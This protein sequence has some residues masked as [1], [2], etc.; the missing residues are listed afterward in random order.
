MTTGAAEAEVRC[1]AVCA[2]EPDRGPGPGVCVCVC[3]L[4]AVT[5]SALCG[6]RLRATASRRATTGLSR[7]GAA[8]QAAVRGFNVM[9]LPPNKVLP[10]CCTQHGPLPADRVIL[11]LPSLCD[12][13]SS[14][15][16]LPSLPARRSLYAPGHFLSGLDS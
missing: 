5:L 6:R 16:P 1:A 4:M 15:R 7:V 12:L 2:G 14:S 13:K 8:H 9:A 3:K 10:V 11:S